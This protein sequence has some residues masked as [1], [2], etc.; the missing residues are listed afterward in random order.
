MLQNATLLRVDP[1]P[2]APPGVPRGQ[3][4]SVSPLT[5][6]DL[7]WL[8]DNTNRAPTAAVLY[9]PLLFPPLETVAIVEGDWLLIQLDGQPPALWRAEY[10]DR[11]VGNVI[12][13]W[14]VFLTT[15]SE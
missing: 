13:Y 2:P 5:G 3:R 14:R 15:V 11:R 12:R 8:Q 4:C 9:L 7:Q 10:V 1:P 6:S